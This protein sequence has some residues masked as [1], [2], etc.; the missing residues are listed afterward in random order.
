MLVYICEALSLYIQI[1]NSVL[2]ELM[3]HDQSHIL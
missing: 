3:A 2:A 1:L